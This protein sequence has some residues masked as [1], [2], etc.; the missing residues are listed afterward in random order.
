MA[1]KM[2]ENEK[3]ASAIAAAHPIPRL[4]KPSDTANEAAFLLSPDSSWT[5]GVILP[6]DG[7]R[8]SILK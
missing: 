1:K 2:T 6:V 5:T 8:S 3:I 7:G 4:G